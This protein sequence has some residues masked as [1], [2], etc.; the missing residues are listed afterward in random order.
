MAQHYSDPK[1]AAERFA[2][3]QTKWQNASTACYALRIALDARYQSYRYAPRPRLRKLESLERAEHRAHERFYAFLKAISP[4]NWESGVPCRWAM[5][6]LTYED[7]VTR[8]QLAHVPDPA[9]GYNVTDMQRFSWPL[10][11]TDTE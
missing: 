3:L 4:R 6:K 9:F 11:D 1:R 7:A 8:G 5:N 2:E 10:A